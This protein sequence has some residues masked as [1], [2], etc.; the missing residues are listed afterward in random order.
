MASNSP[1]DLVGGYQGLRQKARS[2]IDGL[3]HL[4]SQ[5][6]KL[7]TPQTGLS[8]RIQAII[9][10]Q[11][12]SGAVPASPPGKPQLVARAIQTHPEK[13]MDIVIADLEDSLNFMRGMSYL[14][15]EPSAM[16]LT[17]RTRSD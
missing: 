3:V 6:K 17:P 11:R 16:P 14:R 7:G 4:Q 1:N 5:Q 2:L 12:L 8:V 15:V 13:A 9:Q 10:G